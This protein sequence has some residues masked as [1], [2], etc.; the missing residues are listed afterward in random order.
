MTKNK[1][2]K[3]NPAKGKVKEILQFD[4]KTF[5]TKNSFI[6]YLKSE[7]EHLRRQAEATQE[8]AK[9]SDETDAH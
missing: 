6:I 8:G 4:G 7:L 1:K 3:E 2:R 9:P 5:A